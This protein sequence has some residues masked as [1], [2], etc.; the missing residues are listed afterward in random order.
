MRIVSPV[1][2][3]VVYP[4]LAR[5]GYLRRYAR[6]GQLC[7]VTYHG[8]RPAGYRSLDAVFDGGLL[9]ASTFRDQIRLLK[10]RYTVV[11]PSQFHEWIQRKAELPPRAVLLTCDDGLKNTLTEMAPVLRDEGVSCLF[12]VTG[13]STE[14][15]QRMLWYEELY[16]MLVAAPP[17]MFELEE[18]G[19][20][21]LL[22]EGS[23]RRELWSQIVKRLSRYDL[24]RR[25]AFMDEVREHCGLA[26]G[27]STV[28]WNDLARRQRLWLLN[29]KDLR[30]LV[31][32]GM[33]VGA[34]TLSHPALAEASDEI[35]WAEISGSRSRLESVL[36]TDIWALAYPFG[37]VASVTEREIRMAQESG[38]QCAFINYGGG[39][40]ADFQVYAIPRV[41]VTA[42]MTLGELEARV[43]GFYR[44]LRERW[45]HEDS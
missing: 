3:R 18:L 29:L 9:S 42:D 32:D 34:H 7:V 19:V 1:L 35:T 28:Y 24:T 5:S 14:E 13:A 23:P 44:M 37:D 4:G 36:G 25:L 11:T 43:S 40:G 20:R 21:E 16:L 22:A 2:K 33:F 8:I 12:F 10:S 27:W 38:F 31:S 39:F 26:K 17:R 15:E 41:H 6:G 30:E 45:A